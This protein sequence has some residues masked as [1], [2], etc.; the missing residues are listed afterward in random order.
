MDLL[1]IV[2]ALLGL[3]SFA[4]AFA[5]NNL[6]AR[7][8]DIEIAAQLLHETYAKKD[9]VNRDF[10]LIRKSLERIENLLEQKAPKL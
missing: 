5:I 1:W 7:M 6:Y 4:G 9:D 10:D 2:N 8:R 3:L